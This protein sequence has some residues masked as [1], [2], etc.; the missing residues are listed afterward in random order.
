MF[1]LSLYTFQAPGKFLVAKFQFGES[2]G[3]EFGD[4]LSWA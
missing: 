1:K 2:L 3:K 4:R